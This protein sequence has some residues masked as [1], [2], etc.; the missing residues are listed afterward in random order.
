MAMVVAPVTFGVLGWLLDT[1]VG[2]TPLFL[3]LFALFGVAAS[4]ASAYY[5]YSA[6]I[7]RE[8]EGKPWARGAA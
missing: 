3:L 2:T 1:Q 6:R 4:F 8:S 7:T 5:R